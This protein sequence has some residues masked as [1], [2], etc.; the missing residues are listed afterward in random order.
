MAHAEATRTYLTLQL[1]GDI[2][3]EDVLI[4][5][6]DR[7]AYMKTARINN[8]DTKDQ[9]RAQAFL[10]WHAAKR[11]GLLDMT[12]E[13]FETEHLVDIDGAEIKVAE[14]TDED[15]TPAS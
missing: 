8:W 9:A 1:E 3:H 15:P 12:F 13:A 4:I 2:V 7:A 14:D 10:G 5:Y 6:R 11:L